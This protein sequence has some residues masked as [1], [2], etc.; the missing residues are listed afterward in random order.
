MKKAIIGLG[1]L[2]IVILLFMG[3]YLYN[4]PVQSVDKLKVNYII[5][6]NELLQDYLKNEKTANE[7]YLDKTLV[8]TGIIDKIENSNGLTSVYLNTG[9][10]I[11]KIICQLEST[12][13]NISEGQTVKIKGVCTGFLMDVVLIRSKRV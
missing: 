7:K 11:S 4:K 5:N 2:T 13:P 12:D 10:D 1:F 6:S 9:N 8:V 3:G